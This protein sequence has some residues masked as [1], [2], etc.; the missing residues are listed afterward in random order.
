MVAP[1]L[2][3]AEPLSLELADFAARDHDRRAAAL[4]RRLGLEIVRV[5]EAAAKL[6]L[7]RRGSPSP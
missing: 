7:E 3:A 2:D 6:S 1:R 4:A 5:L